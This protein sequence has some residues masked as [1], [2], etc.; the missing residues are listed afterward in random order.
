MQ[1]GTKLLH[2]HLDHR[3]S[4]HR[5][6][7]DESRIYECTYAG[8]TK[9]VL[10]WDGSTFSMESPPD[11]VWV[12]YTNGA[13]YSRADKGAEMV[14]SRHVLLDTEENRIA[15]NGIFCLMQDAKRD[16]AVQMQLVHM[17]S[18]DDDI[19]MVSMI[20]PSYLQTFE[21]YNKAASNV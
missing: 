18:L 19:D 13:P 3:L 4:S 8:P 14:C 12:C 10:H 21:K 9:D 20:D 11:Y 15:L 5:I 1:I 7:P 2:F 17:R 16:Y 6:E